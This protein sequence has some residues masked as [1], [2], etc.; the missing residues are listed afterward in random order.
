MT[1]LQQRNPQQIKIQTVSRLYRLLFLDN[2]PDMVPTFQQINSFVK[3]MTASIIYVQIQFVQKITVFNMECRSLGFLQDVEVDI[4]F[5]NLFW[6]LLLKLIEVE[7]SR[8]S[9]FL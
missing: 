5:Q 8:S 1:E 2:F 3:Q 6:R 7:L 9:N 4:E